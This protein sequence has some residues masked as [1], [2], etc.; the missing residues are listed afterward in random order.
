MA[1]VVFVVSGHT[2]HIHCTLRLANQLQQ[3]GHTVVYIGHSVARGCVERNGH[4]FEVSL[5]V[6]RRDLPRTAPNTRN[7]P[8]EPARL[9]W[10]ERRRANAKDAMDRARAVVGLADQVMNRIPP[11]LLMFDPFL[12]LYYLPFWRYR[13]PAV[14][15][16]AGP[17]ADWDP[18]VPPITSGLIP[19]TSPWSAL[20]VSMAWTKRRITLLGKRLLDAAGA[21]TYGR[22]GMSS[23]KALAAETGFPLGRGWKDVVRA[24]DLFLP[25]LVLWPAEFDFPR[26]R[27]CRAGVQYVGPSIELNR[28]EGPFDWDAVPKCS[29]LVCCQF[30]T[31]ELP[32]QMAARAAFIHRILRAFEL[33]PDCALIL[34]C[35]RSMSVERLADPPPNVR[36]FN[37]IPNLRVLRAAHCHITHGGANSVK[38]SVYLGVPMVVYPRGDDQP[39]NAA[40]VVYH[41]LGVQ[42]NQEQDSPATIAAH[43]R[44]V[45]DDAAYRSNV[46]HLRNVF[47]DYDRRNVD[48]EALE[49]LLS[50]PSAGLPSVAAFPG[51]KLLSAAAI[52]SRMP[53]IRHF[54]FGVPTSN[55]GDDNMSGTRLTIALTADQKKQIKDVTGKDVTTFS[56]DADELSQ[57][58][59]DH[60]AGGYEQINYQ[61]YTQDK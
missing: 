22:S 8:P 57:G 24:S 35:G 4:R 6:L 55:Q 18:Q 29:R 42:G 36:I 9:S 38:E 28:V 43:V 30:G 7:L 56:L 53:M 39:G 33:L 59:L 40:R 25:E 12:L 44:R 27:S 2:G 34:A 46:Q 19:S 26:A 60:A 1:T 49:S 21:L 31:V 20:Q 11:D 54:F 48:V 10:F 45:L 50:R 17:L 15:L 51:K 37:E 52:W 14:V 61:Y 16:T 41:G 32:S 13:I 3:R 58:Q 47:L 5:D 23:L